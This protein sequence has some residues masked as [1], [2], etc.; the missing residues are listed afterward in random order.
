MSAAQLIAANLHDPVL[1]LVQP[2][3]VTLKATQTVTAAYAAVRA[4]ASAR[5]ILP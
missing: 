2:V 4:A 1:P 5:D 3:P